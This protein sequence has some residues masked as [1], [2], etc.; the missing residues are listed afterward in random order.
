M[1]QMSR[2]MGIILTGVLMFLSFQAIADPPHSKPG[3]AVDTLYFRAFDVDRAP[4][5][6]EAGHMDLY[7]YNLKT[8]AAQALRCHHCRQ[9]QPFLLQRDAA[10]ARA[11]RIK[12]AA[13][14]SP[15]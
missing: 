1:K 11:G 2:Y 15:A 14:P 3:P 5:D 8:A 7:M 12:R 9:Q 10:V 6:M 4:R 13:G